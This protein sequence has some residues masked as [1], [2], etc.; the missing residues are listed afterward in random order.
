M[1]K[2]RF[3]EGQI[4]AILKELKAG[5]KAAE[6]CREPRQMRNRTV[7]VVLT[8]VAFTFV[9]ARAQSE[10]GDAARGAQAFRTCAACHSLVP[11]QNMTEPFGL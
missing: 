6:L 9:D 4:V 5:A 2:S 7:L 11:N 8:V 10:P 1:R 3:T